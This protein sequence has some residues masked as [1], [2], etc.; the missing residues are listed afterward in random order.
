MKPGPAQ[1]L[2]NQARAIANAFNVLAL[3]ASPKVCARVIA[4]GAA[5]P[6]PPH[7]A[8][9]L[10]E[11]IGAL[12]GASFGRT[13]TRSGR[14]ALPTL[15]AVQRIALEGDGKTVSPELREGARLALEVLDYPEPPGG[16]DMFEGPPEAGE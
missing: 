5:L 7:I 6:S 4:Q 2:A 11:L 15:R 3:L 10:E 9:H 12:E 14:E 1:F 8:E 13:T 16:W